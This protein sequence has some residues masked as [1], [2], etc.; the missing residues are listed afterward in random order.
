MAR[1][2]DLYKEV[3]RPQLMKDFSYNNVFEAPRVDKIVLNACVGEATQDSKKLEAVVKEMAVIAGQQPVIT[4]AKKSIAQFKLREGMEI[5]AKVTLRRQRMYE[6]LDR[7]VN[8]ALPRVRD[9]RGLSAKS[10]DGHGNY[11]LGIKEQIIFPEINY[12][13]VEKVRGFDVI[14][15]TTA[16]SDAEAKALLSAFNVPFS[17]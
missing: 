8:I 7:L 17:K 5:G 11:A 2:Y 16:K 15:C 14:I 1:L 10:F 3:I 4:T 9:F 6:F 12:D 13:K